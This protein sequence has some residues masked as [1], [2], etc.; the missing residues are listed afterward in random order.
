MGLRNVANTWGVNPTNLRIRARVWDVRLESTSFQ[1]LLITM[2]VLNETVSLKRIPIVGSSSIFGLRR[3]SSV[4]IRIRAAF[5]SDYFDSAWEK[6]R[7]LCS[8]DFRA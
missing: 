1:R 2:I 4:T 8:L 3:A 5:C 6:Q 7:R